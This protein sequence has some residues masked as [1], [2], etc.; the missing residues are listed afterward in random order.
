MKKKEK[1]VVEK[2]KWH[3]FKEIKYAIVPFFIF[4]V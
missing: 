2:E 1:V 4:V 3:F